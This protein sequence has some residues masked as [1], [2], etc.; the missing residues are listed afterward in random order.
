VLAAKTPESLKAKAGATP[1]RTRVEGET[2][3][4][5]QAGSLWHRL[6]TRVQPKLTVSAPNDP[7]EREADRVA[8][9]VMRM[10]ASE[11]APSSAPQKVS[12]KCAACDEEEEKLQKKE[13]GTADAASGEAP[14]I[15][16]EVL[17][18]PGQPLD[19]ATRAYFEPRFGQDFSQVR[20]HAGAKAAASAR[21]VN[22][23]AYTQGRNVVFAAG[24]YAPGTREG[25]RLLAHELA[26]VGQQSAAP[27]ASAIFRTVTDFEI[28][29][30]FPDSASFPNL[31]FFDK[32]GSLID[33]AEEAKI[34]ALALPA[35]DTLT[36]NGFASEE[37]SAATATARLSAVS[38]KLVA[39]GHDPAKVTKVPLPSSG[40]GR[41]DYRRLRSVEILKPG[42]S[43]AVPP[44]I[45]AATA[46]CAGSNETD[47]K[48]AEAE[49]EAMI[50]KSVTALAPPIPAAMTTLLTRLFRGW[51]AADAA[52][53]KTN[54]SNIKTQLHRLL[55]AANHQC[56]IIKY[57]AC[58]S[59]TEAENSGSGAAAMMTMCPTFFDSAKSKKTRGG[60]LIHEA[61]HGTPGLVT[62]DKA[63]AHERLI[64]FLSV[65]DALKNSDSYTLLVRLFD[66]PGSMIVGPATP[67]PLAGGITAGSPEEQAARRT[68]AWME[69]W[70]I[71]SYQEMS[72]L[73]NT[74]HASIAAG[75]WTNT[76]YRGTMSL[77]APLFGLTAPPALP[78]ETDK[79]KVAAIHDR[80]HIMRSVEWSTAITLKKVAAGPDKWAAGP[81][82]SADLSPAFFADTPRGQLDRMLTAIATATRDVSAP[83]VPKYVALAD[84]IRTHMGGGAPPP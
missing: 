15:V 2:L 24:G 6:A 9:Q 53:I 55:P 59:G 46:P 71:W 44:A 26:H 17:R 64:E 79:V 61:A 56:G 52:T 16:H 36:L 57:A 40:K 78:T 65:T 33:A 22:A 62:E 80:F 83:F 19:D 58:E 29:G 18:S 32:D 41:I 10:P 74:I 23:L 66:A 13:A 48:D 37:E 14:A 51:A 38:G 4:R 68:I 81:G 69:K 77:V 8:D 47:F 34:A 11:V 30:K 76:Y 31:I 25:Q 49:A 50:A 27:H 39:H 43:S 28:R 67:D 3:D 7:Y 12:R 63:Y 70:L 5:T 60:T 75:A 45:A 1:S 84:K 82:T 21:E 35:S 20:V 73:Y 42:A 54:L 72:S